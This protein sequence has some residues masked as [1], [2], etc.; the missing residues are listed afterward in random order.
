MSR[1][2]GPRRKEVF[3]SPLRAFGLAIGAKHA[4]GLA[5]LRACTAASQA[6]GFLDDHLEVHQIAGATIPQVGFLA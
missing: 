6:R 4:M 3:T 2:C 5:G 1:M